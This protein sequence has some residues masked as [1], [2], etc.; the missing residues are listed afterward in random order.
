MSGIATAIAG[1]AIVGSIAS[2]RAGSK[3]AAATTEGA[4]TAAAETRRA[5][6][7]ARTDLFKLF[8]AAQGNAEAGFQSALNIFSQSIPAQTQA[9]QQGN[10]A[11]QQQILAGLPQFQNAILGG[12]VDF[13][14]LQ[15][16]QLQLSDFSQQQPAQQLAQPGQLPQQPLTQ[17]GQ[18]LPQQPALDLGFSQQQ[19][20]QFTDPFAPQQL[21]IPVPPRQ[22]QDLP[23]GS[24]RFNPL[25][26]SPVGGF[27]D[28]RLIK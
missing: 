15:P 7:Q 3:A 11:A 27:R 5:T 20:P 24:G 9:F 2:S 17:P 22:Q 18:L 25:G 6:E 26:G 28:D 19:L 16:F 10:V 13:G 12:Q 8:P 4:A 23:L 1:A 14:Q 21:D